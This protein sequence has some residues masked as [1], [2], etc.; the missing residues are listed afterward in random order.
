LGTDTC[1]SIRVPAAGSG[2]RKSVGNAERGMR[3]AEWTAEGIMRMEDDSLS[4]LN[5]L[6]APQGWRD[7]SRRGGFQG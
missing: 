4:L 6:S 3:N 7:V 2:A 1:G 5:L